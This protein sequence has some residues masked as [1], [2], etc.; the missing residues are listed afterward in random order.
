MGEP[1]VLLLAKSVESVSLLLNAEDNAQVD[2][3]D[4]FAA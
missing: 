3:V 2:N 1:S 4:H